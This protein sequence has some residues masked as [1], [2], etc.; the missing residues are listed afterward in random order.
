MKL[1]VACDFFAI[2]LINHS[3]YANVFDS[4]I[5]SRDIQEGEELLV[6]YKEFEKD[7]YWE[8]LL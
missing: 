7:N 4:G 1:V 2:S 8:L 3:S 5:A 6:D